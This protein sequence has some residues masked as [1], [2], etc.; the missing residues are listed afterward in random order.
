MVILCKR[1]N[2][3]ENRARCKGTGLSYTMN[4]QIRRHGLLVVF[5]WALAAHAIYATAQ[6]SVEVIALKYRTAE[7]VIPVLQP[8]LARDGSVSGLRG[9]LVVRT[10][11]ANLKELR[12]VL[13]S[14]DVAPRRLLITVGQDAS[15]D[16]T[17]RGGEI[18]GSLR[19]DDQLRLT[20]PGSTGTRERDRVQARVYDTRS[21]DNMRVMQRVQVLEGRS[22]FVQS[23][24]AAP[25]PQRRVVRSVVNGRVI[26]QVVDGVEYAQ[27]ATGFHVTPRVT[28][29]QVTLE[30]A[31]QREAFVQRAPGMIDVQHV[32]STVSG[33]LGD[34]IELAAVSQ[35]RTAERDV[36]L[37]RASTT[38]TENRSV[39]LKVE[40]LR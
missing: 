39:L 27:V 4:R 11:P 15:S 37:G 31:P 23:G 29:D 30:V 19:A 22:A 18:S 21:L 3:D 17:R 33:R 32:V 40:E 8:M 5:A 9:Q 35:D 38:R 36:L 7:E 12:R 2:I 28:G 26:E 13:D 6:M 14:I 10:T 24:T 34:W 25:L 20:V 16:G 1:R